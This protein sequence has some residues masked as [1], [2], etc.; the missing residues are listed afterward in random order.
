M[1]AGGRERSGQGGMPARRA[2]T[3]GEA[4]AGSA[5]TCPLVHAPTRLE[6]AL[7]GGAAQEV[8][9]RAGVAKHEDDLVGVDVLHGLRGSGDERG[10][11]SEDRSE[12]QRGSASERAR[13]TRARTVAGSCGGSR[14]PALACCAIAS[15]MSLSSWMRS[16]TPSITCSRQ[17]TM[18]ASELRQQERSTGLVQQQQQQ[19]PR[20]STLNNTRLLLAVPL[21]RPPAPPAPVLFVQ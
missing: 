16:F 6:R 19:Q 17:E 7:L 1:Q 2:G 3:G 14:Q 4:Q 12:A 11:T 13:Q 20:P 8:Q 5:Q 10:R 15:S 9:D 18:A 21:R